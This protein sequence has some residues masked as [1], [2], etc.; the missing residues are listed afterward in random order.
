MIGHKRNTECAILGHNTKIRQY[1]RRLAT[2]LVFVVFV[3]FVARLRHAG[4]FA[5]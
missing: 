1:L 3:V 2:V 4:V 5:L